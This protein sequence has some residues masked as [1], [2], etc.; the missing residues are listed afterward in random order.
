MR[1]AWLRSRR[2]GCRAK[3]SMVRSRVAW[4]G[5][6]MVSWRS[7]WSGSQSG[8]LGPGFGGLDCAVSVGM[9]WGCQDVSRVTREEGL[10]LTGRGVPLFGV[11]PG[12]VRC[13]FARW[14]ISAGMQPMSSIRRPVGSTAVGRR[15]PRRPVPQGM[16]GVGWGD[17]VCPGA[18]ASPACRER[19]RQGIGWIAR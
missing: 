3:T 10:D 4:C 15:E 6:W 18:A 1:A 11:C 16:G 9:D 19:G 2:S 8:Q 13:L 17:R 7:V 12:F 5:R 14:C